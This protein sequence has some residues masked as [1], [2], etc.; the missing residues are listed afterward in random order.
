MADLAAADFSINIKKRRLVEGLR[1]VILDLVFGDASKV[2]V[3][4]GIPLPDK[5]TM[6]IH[7]E[8]LFAE[9]EVKTDGYVYVIDRANHKL[10]IF[11]GDYNNSNDGPLIQ[12]PNT[13]APVLNTTLRVRLTGN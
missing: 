13:Y 6:G 12:V 11:F 4:D 1:E 3:T 5:S 10:L 8:I 2:Y 9:V 7:K